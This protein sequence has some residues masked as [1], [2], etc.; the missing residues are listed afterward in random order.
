[1]QHCKSMMRIIYLCKFNINLI[2][3]IC[4]GTI[5]ILCHIPLN[6]ITYSTSAS[7]VSKP[8]SLNIISSCQKYVLLNWFYPIPEIWWFPFKNANNLWHPWS[9]NDSKQICQL[10]W[11]AFPN[12][13]KSNS[14]IN[15]NFICQ[16][17]QKSAKFLLLSHAWKRGYT[18]SFVDPSWPCLVL[19]CLLTV[20][21]F[22]FGTLVWNL[23]ADFQSKS[24]SLGTRK[25]LDT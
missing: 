16:P 7:L 21:L 24:W 17:H 25:R 18:C 2:F 23:Q 14:N 13:K 15:R 8:L 4:P 19:L 22:L 11:K 6:L 3:Q 10:S 1:M 20:S 5:R 12:L 9:T